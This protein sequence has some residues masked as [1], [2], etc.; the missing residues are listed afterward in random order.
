[1]RPRA[2]AFGEHAMDILGTARKFEAVLSQGFERA[3]E[4]VRT[5]GPLQPLEIAHAIVE[6]VAEHVLPGGRGRYVF[7]YHRVKVSI[8]APTKD[9]RAPLEAVIDGSP[10]L[11]E[12]ILQRL[13]SA[14]CVATN[15]DVRTSYV[16]AASPNWADP[17]FNL[18]LL[19]LGPP[20]PSSAE[21]PP[22]DISPLKLTIEQGKAERASYTFSVTP[23]N[24]G[25]CAEIRDSRHR[26]I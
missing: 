16:S 11:S 4:H 24:L 2:S 14:G 17:S 23:I 20:L 18:E 21:R 26:L 13:G 1:M 5:P 6:A 12:R 8:V 25:R 19:R 9:A 22:Q 10:S 15:L 7:P 3:A